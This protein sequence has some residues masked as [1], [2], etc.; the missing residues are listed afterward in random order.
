MPVRD[1]SAV[2]Q[3]ACQWHT[4]VLFSTGQDRKLAIV[5]FEAPKPLDPNDRPQVEAFLDHEQPVSD[6]IIDSY[7][8]SFLVPQWTNDSSPDI[9]FSDKKFD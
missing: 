6:S 5:D 1:I 4:K 3:T 2:I 9:N 8:T 7:F